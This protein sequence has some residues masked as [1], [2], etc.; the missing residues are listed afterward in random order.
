M[1]VSN[2]FANPSGLFALAFS[3]LFLLGS[4]VAE[5]KRLGGGGSFGLQRQVSPAPAPKPPAT[6]PQAKPSTAAGAAA[7][8]N[9][10]SG[11]RFGMLG[12]LAAGLGLVALFSFLGFG[13]GLA[14]IAMLALF[15]LGGVLIARLLLRGR[16]AMTPADGPDLQRQSLP[17]TDRPQPSPSSAGQSPVYD[18]APPVIRP[19]TGDRSAGGQGETPDL[20]AQFNERAFLDLARRQFVRLQAAHDSGDLAALKPFLTPALHEAL[21]ASRDAE[22]G[23]RTDVLDLNGEL[24]ELVETDGEYVASVRF[25]G[26]LRE[27]ADR[28]PTNFCEFWHLTKP[29]DGSRGW[30]LAGIQNAS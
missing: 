29:V 4:S 2:S 17:V 3:L 11:S 10:R 5:A 22:T 30:L 25:S 23:D 27:G 26:L 21:C 12:G 8:A 24:V 19:S 20:R 15:L 7:T 14:V 6:A 9:A 13:E 16:S 1:N 18:T 28:A